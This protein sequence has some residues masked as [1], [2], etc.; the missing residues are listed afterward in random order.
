MFADVCRGRHCISLMLVIK[1]V[2]MEILIM[3]IYLRVGLRH[4]IV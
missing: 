3:G 4:V 2:H 1:L